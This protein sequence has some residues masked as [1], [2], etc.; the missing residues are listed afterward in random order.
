MN[1]PPAALPALFEQHSLVVTQSVRPSPQDCGQP[2]KGPPPVLYKYKS[3]PVLRR[4]PPPPRRGRLFAA[5]SPPVC[6]L[7]VPPAPP[8]SRHCPAP[9]MALQHLVRKDQGCP[10]SVPALKRPGAAGKLF[11]NRPIGN[12]G[13]MAVDARPRTIVTCPWCRHVRLGP[14]DVNTARPLT[15]ARE[16]HERRPTC[17]T[18]F[19]GVEG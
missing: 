10:L 12:D 15:A 8:S 16:K 9:E 5:W 2:H 13:I 14:R 18:A 1:V 3:L 11:A 7:R 4:P 6:R 17:V 19:K